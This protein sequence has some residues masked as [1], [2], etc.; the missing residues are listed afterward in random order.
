MALVRKSPKLTAKTETC[1]VTDTQALKACLREAAV[2]VQK[3][4]AGYDFG[5]SQVGGG[6]SLGKINESGDKQLDLDIAADLAV[7]RALRQC[8]LIAGFLSEERKGFVETNSGGQYVVAFDPLDGSQNVPVGITVGSIYGVFKG[9]NPEDI[10]EAPMARDRLVCA[11]Y[12]IHSAALLFNFCDV[13]T[14]PTL[15]R[16]D[17]KTQSWFT[18]R[19]EVVMPEKGKTYCINE[20]NVKNWADWTRDFVEALKGEKRSTRWMACM[21][22]DVHRPLLQ[23]GIFAYPEDAKY[24]GGRLRLVYEGMP[25][26]LLWEQAGGTALHSVNGATGEL[27]H[28]LDRPFPE[29]DIHCRSGVVFVGA[30]EA[31]VLKSVLPRQTSPH[32]KHVT[33]PLVNKLE[34]MEGSIKNLMM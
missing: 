34:S 12:A 20:G 21:V 6:L 33:S 13:D 5:V 25:M 31:K 15:E 26:A 2:A 11:A 27:S 30:H 17:L 18:V 4:V 7:E 1:G 28:I 14:R 32:V 19:K 23:G 16:W 3:V 29:T 9:K 24:T 10:A 8:P 22:S